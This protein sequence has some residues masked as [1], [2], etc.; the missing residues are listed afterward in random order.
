M[1]KRERVQV[2]EH[3]AQC[4]DCR[5]IVSLSTAPE[6]ASNVSTVPVNPGW[7]SWPVLRWGA[8]AACVLVVGAAVT[9]R[10]KQEA[11]PPASIAGEKPAVEMQLPVPNSAIE[12]KVVS[13]QA[14]DSEAQT[15]LQAKQIPNRQNTVTATPA[16]ENGAAAAGRPVEMAD[17]RTASPFAEMV[18]G[19][20]KTAPEESQNAQ[21][22]NEN[23]GPLTRNRN[24]AAKRSTSG[25]LFSPNLIPRWT[26][27]A[28]GTL[29]RSLDSG[30][31]WQTIPV[32]SQTIFRALAA[33]GLEI[34]VGGADGALFHSSDAGQHWTQVRPVVDGEALE[35]DIIGVEFTDIL[36]GKLTTSS[37]ETWT[38]ADAG[39][40][41]R[42]W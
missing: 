39:Q 30:T 13:L 15:T 2:F 6:I 21:A 14:P 35:D 40:T 4:T 32:S 11:R 33:D 36:H 27:S 19:R 16:G 17:A 38:T 42:K 22:E 3:L 31:T 8:L 10:H 29:Q 12:K 41:W 37:E 24:M 9:L 20:A 28:D 7:L 1:E 5:E 26:L 18:P 23:G 34:W 25:T